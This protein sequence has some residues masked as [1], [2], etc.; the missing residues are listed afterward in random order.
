MIRF[1]LAGL[2][3]IGKR[4]AEHI[5]NHPQA[6][7]VAVCDIDPSKASVAD[8]PFFEHIGDMLR[9]TDADV[10]CVCTPNYL[11]E[12]HAVAALRSGRHVVVE[13]PMALSVAECDRMIAASE[14]SDKLIFAV[15]QNRYN[16][17]VAAVKEL[18]D[19]GRLGKVFLVQVNCFWNRGDSYYAQSDWRGRKEKDGGC[20]FTQFSHFVDILYYLNGTIVSARGMTAN[21]AHQHNTEF[22]D[23]G[24]FVMQGANGSMINFNFTTAAFEKNMEGA[25]T[26]FA[27]HGTVKIG[28]QYLNTIEYQ[29][30]EGAA[31]PSINISAKNNDYGLYQGS[32]SNHDKLID[33]VVRVLEHGDKMTT[34]AAEGREVVRMIELMYRSV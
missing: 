30:L 19:S 13:K 29:Q 16:P 11:H 17:P 10:V 5:L 14:D 25:I 1:A 31:L 7:L 3:N 6:Q 33:N 22:E 4:H 8:V 21:F 18:I 2:G 27:E 24:S 28:G 34:T 15:K 32:M 12:P 20:L 9:E 23:S 26:V